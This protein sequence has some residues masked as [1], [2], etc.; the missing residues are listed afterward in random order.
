VSSFTMVLSEL[1]KHIH[2]RLILTVILGAHRVARDASDPLANI[3]LE[4]V[5]AEFAVNAISPLFAA[6]EAVKGFK[7]LPDS[8]S[9]TFIMTGNML[10]KIA[11]PNVLTFG[12]GKSAAASMVWAASKGYK[13]KGY[14]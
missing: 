11:L 5:T 4:E 12:A 10:N 14:R 13:D 6:Q 9:K 3:T 8:A 2:W 1:E 7:Q